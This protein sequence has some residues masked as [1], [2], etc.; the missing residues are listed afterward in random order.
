[1]FEHLPD[2]RPYLRELLRLVRP[3]GL[4]LV[5]TDV[6]TPER[7]AGFGQ[8]VVRA[9]P[10]HCCFYRHRTFEAF[11][12]GTPH[13]ILYREPKAVMIRRDAAEG[14]RATCVGPRSP[15]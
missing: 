11:L 12:A 6:E 15:Q 10:D 4:V 9:P 5:H 2:P 14:E 7:A 3:G 8:V 13:R 1:M